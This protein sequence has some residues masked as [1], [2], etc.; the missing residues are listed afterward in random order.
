MLIGLMQHILGVSKKGR[1]KS[2]Q[3]KHIIKELSW[4]YCVTNTAGLLSQLPK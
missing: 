1:I 3:R 2:K 4:V